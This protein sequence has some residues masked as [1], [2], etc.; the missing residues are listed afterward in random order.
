MGSALLSPFLAGYRGKATLASQ[1]IPPAARSVDC[2]FRA[3]DRALPV[4]RLDTLVYFALPTV[5]E[6]EEVEERS[7]RETS[8]LVRQRST[9]GAE[10]L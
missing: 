5:A 1:E 6:D 9:L 4:E 10:G 8:S 3:L 2:L 7:L